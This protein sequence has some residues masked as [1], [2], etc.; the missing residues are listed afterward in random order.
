MHDPFLDRLNTLRVRTSFPIWSPDH[1]DKP[2]ADTH[3][4]RDGSGPACG[5]LLQAPEARS[6]CTEPAASTVVAN[7]LRHQDNHGSQVP[8]LPSCDG[9]V[10]W[11]SRVATPM[12]SV[13]YE[14]DQS[15][16]IPVYDMR[17]ALAP[18]YHP[19]A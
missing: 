8:N 14:L 15:N 1:H 11:S 16:D 6:Q 2:D 10:E 13:T 5:N 12:G 17:P 3:D 7:S 18:L 4:P 19:Q 9:G